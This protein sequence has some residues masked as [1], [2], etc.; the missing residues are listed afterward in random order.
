MNKWSLFFVIFFILLFSLSFV[1]SN[2]VCGFVNDSQNFSSSWANV[3]IY[4]DENHSSIIN[5]EVNS[6]NKFCCDTEEIPSFTYT[7]G[8]KIFAE[9]FDQ[10]AGFVAGPVSLYLT[11]EGYD[12]FTQMNL[13]KAIIINSPGERIFI[14]Q[15]SVLLNIS[16]AENYNG[17]RYSLNSSQGFSQENVCNN[18]TSIILPVNLSKGKNEIT[19]TAYGNREISEKITIYNLDYINFELE[20]FCDKCKIKPGYFY[21]PSQENITFSSSF[22]A[23][24]NLSGEF[25]FY[26]PFDWILFNS[27]NLG[28]FSTTH[29][30]LSE[31]ITDKMKFTINY[32]FESPKTLIK[33]EYYFY[34]KLENYELISKVIVFRFK[35]IPFRNVKPFINYYFNTPLN[36]RGS[37]DH[38]IILDSTED[39]LE[40]V[41]IFPKKEILNS[42]SSLKFEAEKNRK[43]KEYVFTI[44]TSILPRDIDKIFLLFKIQKGKS[45]QVFSGTNT[46]HLTLYQQDQNFTYYSAYVHKKGP[47]K[48]RIF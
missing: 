14:N 5:C 2:F 13:Q 3:I 12:L 21:V 11:G 40:T 39:S 48:V 45:I 38:P 15:S 16:L 35:F 7:V 31:N 4:P 19:L 37:T 23:S 17:L 18:C 44:L 47:F 8:K 26:F 24:H 9:I 41:A 20:V 28:D 10:K 27:S 25:L 33:R 6:E 32:T 22:N 46:I 30:I 29:N 36:Q 42:Y 43:N 34:Q 1:S